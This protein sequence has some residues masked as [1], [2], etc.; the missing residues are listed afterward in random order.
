MLSFLNLVYR[1]QFFSY[2][3]TEMKFSMHIDINVNLVTIGK[4]WGGP[5]GGRHPQNCF[6][7]LIWN[8]AS[9]MFID[10][11]KF[12]LRK[13]EAG[14]LGVSTPKT[15]FETSRLHALQCLFYYFAYQYWCQYQYSDWCQYHHWY[16]YQYWCQYQYWCHCKY[17]RSARGTKAGKRE[18]FWICALPP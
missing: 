1:P 18:L 16:K 14:F 17:W 10:W 5:S 6:E 2:R 4:F 9:I 15:F 11:E 3:P 7:R 8:F 13:F 12:S